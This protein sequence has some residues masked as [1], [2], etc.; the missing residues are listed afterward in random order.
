MIKQ[1]EIL[2]PSFSRGY[3]LIANLIENNLP[4]LPDK[5]II[6]I[7]VQHTSAGL[8]INENADLS[9]RVDFETVFNK[10]VPEN[11]RDYIH[12]I[13]GPDDMPAHI[14]SSLVGQ[15]V[16]IPITNKRLNLG[17]WQG[18]YLCE[19][20]NSGGRRKLVITIYS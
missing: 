12:T 20:R 3:H 13:E 2:L 10:L 14:K 5:G 8:T 4:E 15:S 6:N 1:F 9:V 11:S 7:F 16:T 18:I 19:F 17:I